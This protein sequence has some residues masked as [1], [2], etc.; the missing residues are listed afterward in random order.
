MV[1]LLGP[2]SSSSCGRSNSFRRAASISLRNPPEIIVFPLK[3]GSSL[4][5]IA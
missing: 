1:R 4:A 5:A 3:I 2:I